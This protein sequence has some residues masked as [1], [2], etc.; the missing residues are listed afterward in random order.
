MKPSP[1]I[2]QMTLR[3]QSEALVQVHMDYVQLPERRTFEVYGDRG[4]LTYDFMTGEIRHFKYEFGREHRWDAFEVSTIE[5]RDD[6]FRS[7]HESVLTDRVAGR[8][9]QVSGADGLA[10][11]QV[12][13]AAIAAAQLKGVQ[14]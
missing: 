10:A 5:R 2:F 4:T 9:P 13:E 3:M 1:N 14:L 12:A 7:Q 6:V 8:E 11:L